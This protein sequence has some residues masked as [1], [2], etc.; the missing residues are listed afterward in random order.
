M[1]DAIDRVHRSVVDAV[2]E[3]VDDRPIVWTTTVVH[4]IGEF[5]NLYVP[6]ES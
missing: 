3:R 1:N 5:G 6:L 2:G 4:R